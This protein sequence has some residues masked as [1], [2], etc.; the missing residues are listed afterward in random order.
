M[1]LLYL[2]NYFPHSH[3]GHVCR[4]ETYNLIRCNRL[5]TLTRTTFPNSNGTK[6]IS[7]GINPLFTLL[8]CVTMV[9]FI[10]FDVGAETE[11]QKERFDPRRRGDDFN[12]RE[13]AP[14]HSALMP[15]FSPIGGAPA[16]IH[17]ER[18]PFMTVGALDGAVGHAL[19]VSP[20]FNVACLSTHP[21][22]RH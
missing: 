5:L 19:C 4:G 20:A 11:L 3:V 14:T 10:L 9:M 8:S 13:P 15:P 18:I 2:K 1:C 16:S 7:T 12:R 6:S 21:I 22:F 17:H